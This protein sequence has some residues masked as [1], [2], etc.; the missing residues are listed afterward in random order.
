MP[1]AAPVRVSP[2]AVTVFPVA[3]AAVAKVALPV[4]ATTSPPTAPDTVHD[5]SVA[6]VVPSYALL[7]A[8]TVGVTDFGLTVSELVP[9]E[10]A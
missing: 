5:V 10:A 8:V 6:L 1:A 4:Q 9:L 2:E 7:A 3:T